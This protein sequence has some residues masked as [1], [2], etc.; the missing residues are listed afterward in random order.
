MQQLA[1]KNKNSLHLPPKPRRLTSI[2]I[3]LIIVTGVISAMFA[4]ITVDLR[5]RDYLQGRAQTIADTLPA[6][7]I[8]FLEGTAEDAE[9][10]EYKEVKVLLERV[11]ANNADLNFVYIMRSQNDEAIFLVDATEPNSE[12]FSAPGDVYTEGTEQLRSG[13]S[14]NKPFM[15]GPSRDKWGIWLSAFA[16]IADP[17]TGR[18]VG[19]VGIDTP[20]ANYYSEIII[21]ALVPLCLAA[22]P[23]AGLLRDRKLEIKE[24]EVTQL[25]NQF[26]SIAS[27]ELRSPLTGM[28]WAIQSLLKTGNKT[29]KTEQKNL[30]ND[31]FQSAES[32]TATINEILDLTVF[33]RR[34]TSNIRHDNVELVSA[35]REVQRALRLGA[36]EKR[37]AIEME[38]FPESA[39]ITGDLA[40]LKRALMNIISNSVKYSFEGSTIFIRY[41]LE[42]EQHIISVQDHGI[43]IPKAEQEQVLEGYH[44]AVNATKVQARGTGIGLWLTRLI[45]E[46]HGGK[47]WLNSEEDKGTII[48][49]S[50]PVNQQTSD[51]TVSQALTQSEPQSDPAKAK[52]WKDKL[53]H[54]PTK[55]D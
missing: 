23:L 7:S 5:G 10:F 45:I 16:P 9:K 17:A 41:R 35:V 47:L 1:S 28:V 51:G 20:A 33:E 46:E 34:Q 12:A 44:R 11:K 19:W 36:Q 39:I 6:E 3:I 25:K 24:W 52:T 13:F 40:A 49:L 22:I 21:Y 53:L 27:H 4:A 42:N 26:V 29:L 18:T 14:S 55:P 2:V 38:G 54:R 50:L 37:L 8:S 15:E 30:L 48:Y 31:M 32:S 43:G